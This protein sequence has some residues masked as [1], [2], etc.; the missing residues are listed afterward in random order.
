MDRNGKLPHQ[1]QEAI[2]CLSA[3]LFGTTAFVLLFRWLFSIQYHIINIDEEIWEFWLSFGLPW[4]PVL[5][6]FR[7][8]LMVL[9]F[10]KNAD[11]RRF[12]FQLLAAFATAGV[13]GFSQAYLTTATG[14]MET[15]HNISEI[16]TK[17]AVRYYKI[18]KMP[19]DRYYRGSFVRYYT[20][21]KNNTT[22]NIDRYVVS[23]ILL[24]PGDTATS[25]HPYWYGVKFHTSMGNGNK[26]AYKDTADAQFKRECLADMETFN[27]DSLDHFERTPIS[28]NDHKYFM[29]A[30]EVRLD[31][32]ADTG[33]I[34]LT[35]IYTSYE[36]RN[37]DKLEWLLGATGIGMALM[38]LLLL[39]ADID[40]SELDKQNAGTVSPI[41]DDT[42]EMIQFFKP[43]GKYA[44]TAAIIDINILVFVMMVLSGVDISSPSALDLMRW[45][46]DRR[47][48]TMGGDWWRLFTSMFVHSGLA[49]LFANCIGLIFAA[50]LVETILGHKNYLLLYLLAGLGGSVASIWWHA[51]SVSVGASGAIFGVYGAALA[52]ALLNAYPKNAKKWM[53]VIISVYIILNLLWGLTGGIDNAAHIGGLLSGILITIVMYKIDGTIKENAARENDDTGEEAA[54]TTAGN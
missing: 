20:S 15:L 28:N 32:P 52:L 26:D 29:Q 17:Q 53:L 7:P 23:P 25:T 8:R 49:H 35:P 22:F 14:K 1:I 48:E 43:W 44:V 31:H 10:K 40:Q 24:H 19:V 2:P 50:I 45:G 21:G 13:L 39:F 37:G 46:A 42:S 33:Y 51:D 4:I 47:M 18:E 34:V 38:L 36:A 6:W 3:H 54:E 27:Y 41:N 9:S 16:N 11:N 12:Q 5:I 30:I